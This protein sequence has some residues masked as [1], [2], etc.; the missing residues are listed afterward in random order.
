M[1][2]LNHVVQHAATPVS[3]LL[4]PPPFKDRAT[5]PTHQHTQLIQT[6]NP[7]RVS[8]LRRATKPCPHPKQ[9]HTPQTACFPLAKRSPA[10]KGQAL[11]LEGPAPLAARQNLA[12]LRSAHPRPEAGDGSPGAVSSRLSPDPRKRRTKRA[13]LSNSSARKRQFLSLAARPR[14]GRGGVCAASGKAE[15]EAVGSAGEGPAMSR[16]PR[17]PNF[18]EPSGLSPRRPQ[19]PAFSERTGVRG[20][21]LQV[22]CM[23]AELNPTLRGQSAGDSA[24]KSDTH[25]APGPRGTATAPAAPTGE[26]GAGRASSRSPPPPPPPP[27]QIH[28][29]RGSQPRSPTTSPLLQLLRRL[30]AQ[31]YVPKL[32]LE[33]LDCLHRESAAPWPPPQPPP[34]VWLKL[35]RVCS[36]AAS[37]VLPP[38][39]PPPT[40]KP[41]PLSPQPQPR[42]LG[43]PRGFPQ[44]EAPARAP[45]GGIYYEN[46]DTPTPQPS[47]PNRA[48]SRGAFTR[49]ALKRLPGRCLC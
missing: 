17:C 5:R 40:A 14:S 44:E 30:T 34:E 28:M 26:R 11:G 21:S 23:P 1:K 10:V 47:F 36:E 4:L 13:K 33:S 22:A 32:R 42:R 35:S 19:G 41:R 29:G 49:S 24:P 8:K 2:F 45:R 46:S 25:H 18:R 15:R 37:C 27:G 31:H 20:R 9:T 7:V 6:A 12:F 3:L 39:P 48:G 43:H 16:D 38:R